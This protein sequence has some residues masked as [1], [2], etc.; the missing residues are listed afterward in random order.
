MKTFCSLS[1]LQNA[2]N[3]VES[4]LNPNSSFVNE[5]QCSAAFQSATSAHHQSEGELYGLKD[6]YGRKHSPPKSVHV[7]FLLMSPTLVIILQVGSSHLLTDKGYGF[8]SFNLEIVQFENMPNGNAAISE[9]SHILQISCAL[10][11]SGI[12]ANYRKIISLQLKHGT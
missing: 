9:N 2:A 11:Q 1:N 3:D 8:V 10:A 4:F 6:C 12:S 7:A 5:D